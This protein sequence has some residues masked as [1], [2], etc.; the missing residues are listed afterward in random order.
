MRFDLQRAAQRG[1]LDRLRA[2][3]SANP[4]PEIDERDRHGQTALMYALE[5]P[6][7]GADL[8]SL[9]IESGADVHQ[10]CERTGGSHTTVAIC[11]HGGDPK[12]LTVLPERGADVRTA[13]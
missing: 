1:D 3:L 2:L 9:L 6:R 4:A 12:K 8:V 5:S 13:P 7:A 10:E 11:F